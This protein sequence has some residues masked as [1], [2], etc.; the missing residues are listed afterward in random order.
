MSKLNEIK[1]K[2]ENP[3]KENME[4]KNAGEREKSKSWEEKNDWLL[5]L[6]KVLGEIHITISDIVLIDNL[7][8]L[9]RLMPIRERD[10]QNRVHSVRYRK[11]KLGKD[12]WIP[13]WDELMNKIIWIGR[14]SGM[15]YINAMK[16]SQF[17]KEM[18]RNDLGA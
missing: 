4:R 10:V 2:T 5:D 16:W 6:V 15:V 12:Y 1:K 9:K 7:R 8:D 11:G 17:S 14:P 18:N 3:Q 13:L